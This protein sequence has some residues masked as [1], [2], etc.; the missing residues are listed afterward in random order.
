MINNRLVMPTLIHCG[1]DTYRAIEIMI[2]SNTQLKTGPADYGDNRDTYA[3]CGSRGGGGDALD[4]WLVLALS[5]VSASRGACC[6]MIG[7]MLIT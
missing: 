7:P 5:P 6:S 1:E 2:N 3:T 4:S